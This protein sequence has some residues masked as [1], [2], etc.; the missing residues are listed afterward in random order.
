MQ[1]KTR[2]MQS[3]LSLLTIITIAVLTFAYSFS[4]PVLATNV[5][6][7]AWLG[8]KR[9]HSNEVTELPSGL[10]YRVK[11]PGAGNLHPT[12]DAYCSVDYEITLIDGTPVESTR[13]AGDAAMIR[14]E[15]SIPAIQEALQLMVD[16]AFWELYVP[17]HLGYD[18]R[19]NRDVKEGEA[20][21][22]QLGLNQIL[23]GD[24]IPVG[25]VHDCFVE[26]D[27]RQAT[28]YFHVKKS[29]GCD[30]RDQKYI[31]K[32]ISWDHRFTHIREELARL[33]GMLK[34]SDEHMKESLASWARRRI[35]I[36]KQFLSED[37]IMC[38]VR[39]EVVQE[40]RQPSEE[41]GNVEMATM[42]RVHPVDCNFKEQEYIEKIQDW[43]LEK[44]K[45]EIHRLVSYEENSSMEADLASWVRKRLRILNQIARAKAA[46]PIGENDREESDEAEQPEQSHEEL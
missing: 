10:L 32:I 22:V 24:T 23:R 34:K 6:G 19:T 26:L 44:V 36:L 29:A 25:E 3:C 31:E 40:E 7:E 17:S 18:K 42:T 14:P 46:S 39:Y 28:G 35:N 45:E 21:M 2:R 8:Q 20:L 9:K 11:D 27:D 30:E 41:G 16:G 33:R 15:D 38:T 4:V 1:R 43:D 13:Q 12:S 37:M 5:A